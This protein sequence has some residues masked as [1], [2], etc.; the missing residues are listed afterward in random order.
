MVLM[1]EKNKTYKVFYHDGE[2]VRMKFL[3]FIN[4]TV[5]TLIFSNPDTMREE[6]IPIHSFI[7][8]ESVMIDGD[9]ND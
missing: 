3:N 4:E 1:M 9:S 2:R 6:T 8:A 5:A 7:R